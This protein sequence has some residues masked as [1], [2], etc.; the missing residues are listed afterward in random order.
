MALTRLAVLLYAHRAAQ[1]GRQTPT[2]LHILL[3]LAWSGSVGFGVVI[4]LISGDWVVAT[5]AS[6]STAAMVSG[7]CFRNFSAPRLAGAMVVLSLGP[8]IP[9][10]ILAGEPLLY[11]VCLQVPLYLLTTASGRFPGSTGC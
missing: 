1:A 5:L 9:G 11:L 4:S 2:D 8:M 3:A 7:I 6:V 10:V